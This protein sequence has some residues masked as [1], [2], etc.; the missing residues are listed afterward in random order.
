MAASHVA[1]AVLVLHPERVRTINRSVESLATDW[2]QRNFV[3]DVDGMLSWFEGMERRRKRAL[4]R[5]SEAYDQMD[6]LAQVLQYPMMGEAT[7]LAVVHAMRAIKGAEA[8]L[9]EIQDATTEEDEQHEH[10]T[11]EDGPPGD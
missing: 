5:L 1:A 2:R 10:S 9:E 8:I 11:D 7:G 6:K 4:A 3:P